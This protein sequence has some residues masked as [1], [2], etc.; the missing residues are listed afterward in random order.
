M[1]DDYLRKSI[2]KALRDLKTAEQLLT[3]SKDN[4]Y[5]DT[6]CFNSQQAAEKLLKSYLP[7]KKISFPKTHNLKY[8]LKLCIDCDDGFKKL[9]V[10]GLTIYAVEI[11]YPEAYHLPDL[12]EAQKSFS[13]A[14]SIK[15]FILK[16]LNAKEEDFNLFQEII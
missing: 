15:N 9:D 13:L 3:I 10:N 7:F 4:L 6:I 12:K 1:I 5:T 11:R 2:I 8:L 16:K 14:V